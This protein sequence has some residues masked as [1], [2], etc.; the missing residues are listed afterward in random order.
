MSSGQEVGE[1]FG[2][3]SGPAT[4]LL[5]SPT[6]I[7]AS[8]GLWG[9]N[10]YLFRLFRIDYVKVLMLDLIKE[11]EAQSHTE[12][13]DGNSSVGSHGS[14]S[15]RRSSGKML[16]HENKDNEV[17]A[18]RLIIFSISLLGLLHFSTILYI[19]ILNGS[20]IGA[21]FVFY[22][23]VA[24]GIALPIEG[25][26]WIRLA[27]GT[28][29]HRALELVNP[30]CFCFSGGNVVPRAIPFVDVFFADAMCSVR[31]AFCFICAS[32]NADSLIKTF[33]SII[34]P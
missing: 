26:R 10:V 8:V 1:I 23:A 28:V 17:T 7:I 32:N 9:M 18:Y 31:T 29:G 24:V 15:T 11:R 34:L 12:H 3:G 30:R 14:S 20:T 22:T 19:N 21:I 25:T 4:A 2:S 33:A 6:V 13:D 27:C 5:R 16:Q